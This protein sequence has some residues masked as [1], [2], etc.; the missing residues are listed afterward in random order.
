MFTEIV[1]II[2][3]GLQGDKE[4]V[5]NYANYI[6]QT[7][8]LYPDWFKINYFACHDFVSDELI[9]VNYNPTCRELSENI[10]YWVHVGKEGHCNDSDK[11]NQWILNIDIDYFF[12]E[13][14]YQMFTD[15]YIKKICAN[16]LTALPD[17][18]VITISLSPECCGG[19]ENSCRI[20]NL[21]AKEFNLDFE[22]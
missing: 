12:F 6:L 5:F 13:S 1:K 15:E 17:I 10:S 19:W 21:M 7:K 3:G 16:I 22:I 14:E 2:E 8:Q 18:D 20:A 4:K 9:Y 11:L